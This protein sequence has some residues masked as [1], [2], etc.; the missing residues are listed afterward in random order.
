MRHAEPGRLRRLMPVTQPWLGT[1]TVLRTTGHALAT[2]RWVWRAALGEWSKISYQAGARFH[3]EEHPVASLRDLVALLERVSRDRRAFIVRGALAP[4]VHDALA[5][6]PDLLIRRRK[7]KRADD[8]PSLLEMACHWLMVDIDGFPLRSCDDLADDPES[9]IEHA[10]TELLPP[11]FHDAECWWQL[12]AAAGFSVGVLKVH[13]F[14]WLSEPADN[15][16]IKAVLRQHAPGVDRSPFNAAQPHYIAAPVIEGG[17]DPIPRRTGWR[18]GA[19]AVVTLPKPRASAPQQRTSGSSGRVG[20]DVE[21][22]LA[23]LGDGDG[24]EGFH[25]P[26]RTATWRYASQCVRYGERDD[27]AFVAMLKAAIHAAPRRHDRIKVDEYLSPNYQHRLIDGAFAVLA[28]NCDI[29]TISPHY[30]AASQS[31]EDAREALAEHVAAFLLR[32]R[33]WHVTPAEEREPA[34][35]AALVCGLGTGKSSTARG[36]L[37]AFIARQQAA[38]LPHRVLWTVPT[39]KLG[40]EARKQMEALGLQIAVMRGREATDPDADEPDTAMCLAPEAVKDAIAIGADVERSVCGNPDNECCQFYRACGYQRQKAA[41]AAADVV[42]A[43]HNILFHQLA[44]IVT[45]NLALVITDE[46]WWQ[47]GLEPARETKLSSFVD[48]VIDHP[49]LRDPDAVRGLE[50]KK[51]RRPKGAVRRQRADEP[52]TSVLHELAVKAQRAFEATAHG[53]MISREAVLAAGLSPEDCAMARQLDWRRKRLDVLRPG[54]SPEARKAAVRRAA[55]NA[56]LPRRAGIWK[57]L[58]DLLTGTETHSGRLE[59]GLKTDATGSCRVILL[60]SRRDLRD[61]VIESPILLL[62]ATMPL[63]VVQH[64]LP[65]LKVLADVQAAAPHLDTFQILGG[66]GKTS[67]IP[68]SRASPTENLRRERL[69]HELRDFVVFH[70]GGNA[71]VITYRAIEDRFSNLAGVRTG[72]FNA[73]AGLDIFGAVRSLF[74]I[75]RP[76]PDPSTLR[77]MAMALTGRPILVAEPRHE[78]RG[79]LMTDDTSIAMQILAYADPDLEALRAA[80]T[81]NEVLQAAG[82]GRAVNRTADKPMALFFMAGVLVPMPVKQIIRWPDTRLTVQQRMAARGLVTD[83]PTDAAK[84]YPD[85]FPTSEA[86]RKA[87]DRAEGISRTV[88]YD[89]VFIGECPPNARGE[90]RYRPEGRGQQLRRIWITRQRLPAARSDL[91]AALGPLA[92]FDVSGAGTA[93]AARPSEQAMSVPGPSAIAVMSHTSWR[94]DA[95]LPAHAVVVAG[96]WTVRRP[97]LAPM[98]IVEMLGGAITSQLAR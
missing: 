46:A 74:V 86:A 37:P 49:V 29:Q 59:L 62:D 89:S 24:L 15:L 93:D 44:E 17:L 60:H 55:V 94:L 39:H 65:R 16:H 35:H 83:S 63:R 2:K 98:E 81:D 48:D 79:Q 84:L 96:L 76:L 1:V 21:Q 33:R 87:M 70:S 38:R 42:I 45:R 22:A 75:G 30:E 66:W 13:L 69:L 20:G 9:A 78:T 6:D 67:I 61:I 50:G 82:R 40:G 7:L 36:A 31:I 4:W 8:E 43:A 97:N 58:E 95:L 34:E 88:P 56:T 64:Y 14:F 92:V 11:E 91:E 27:A 72:H 54:M 18:K 77:R 26:L 23:L 25:A 57:A 5:H 10:I 90:G 3:P 85:L 80:I 53:E 51:R 47:I 32:T 71:L 52:N 19:E 12:S 28:G 73:I 68:F 41:V